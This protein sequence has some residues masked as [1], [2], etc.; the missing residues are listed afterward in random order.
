MAR[1]AAGHGGPTRTDLGERS[2]GEAW[3]AKGWAAEA[4][5]ARRTNPPED[6][7]T[8]GYS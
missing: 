7:P 3:P 4:S 6:A 5:E 2:A 1:E 8:E